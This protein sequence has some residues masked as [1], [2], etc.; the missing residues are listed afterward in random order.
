MALEIRLTPR[1]R[2]DLASVHDWTWRR[3]GEMQANKYS[4]DIAG[5]FALIA[6]NPGMARDASAIV[7]DLKRTVSG[8][9][10]IFLR[11]T[12]ETLTVVRILHGSMDFDRW[13]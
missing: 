10:V 8:S 11:I 1:A 3:F 6:E 13:L 12:G 4:S 5:A 2:H 9:H 7:R